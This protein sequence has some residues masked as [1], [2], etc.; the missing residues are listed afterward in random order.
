MIESVPIT[1]CDVLG[2]SPTP[3]TEFQF[4]PVRLLAKIEY[5]QPTMSIKYRIAR[6]LLEDLIECG[7]LTE[8]TE[9]VVEATA[10]NT[11]LALER[12]LREL[13]FK[14]RIMAVVS[15]KVQRRKIDRLESEGIVVRVV[16]YEVALPSATH[17]S[18][19]IEAL[20]ATVAGLREAVIAGQFT[21]EANA[22][23]HE[24]GTGREIVEQLKSP[25]DAVVCG[26]GTGGTITGISRAIRK[27]GWPSKVI[28][29]DPQGSILGAAWEGKT[30]VPGKSLVEGI[31]GDFVPDILDLDLIDGFISVPDSESLNAVKRLREMGFSVGNSSGCVVAASLR[32]VARDPTV[33]SCLVMFADHGFW[34][35]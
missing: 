1:V 34:Y 5:L 27:A 10:G 31:G 12:C 32:L 3:I 4:G 16:P 13:G 33:S 24:L 2:K 14:A 19:L 17:A 7:K 25:P 29:A 20:H 26:A 22:R 6:A 15:N 23:A 18:P 8:K 11:A 30:I 35:Q 9:W 21:S 28:L